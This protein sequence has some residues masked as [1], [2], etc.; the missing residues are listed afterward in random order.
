MMKIDEMRAKHDNELDYELATM[1]KELFEL[2]FKSSTQG[3]QSPSKIRQLKRA[4]AR[5]NTLLHERKTSVRGQE[6]H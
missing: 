1:K 6:S 5:V 3:L 2:R 4:I